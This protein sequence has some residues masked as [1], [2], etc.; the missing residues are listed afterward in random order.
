MLSFEIFFLLI[1]VFFWGV[2]EIEDDLVLLWDSEGENVEG[3]GGG[4]YE[5]GG[6]GGSYLGVVGGWGWGYVEVKLW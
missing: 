1:F 5:G 4:D 6:G 2:I 3:F